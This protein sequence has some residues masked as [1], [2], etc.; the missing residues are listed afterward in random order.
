[1]PTRWLLKWP[2]RR[3]PGVEAR[4]LQPTKPQDAVSPLINPISVASTIFDPDTSNNTNT[5]ETPLT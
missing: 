2:G 1:M 3:W 5:L 4:R